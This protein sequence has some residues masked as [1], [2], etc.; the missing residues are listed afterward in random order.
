MGA[1]EDDDGGGGDVHSIGA[2]DGDD[3]GDL[4]VL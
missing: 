3:D 1:N 2:K 4:V